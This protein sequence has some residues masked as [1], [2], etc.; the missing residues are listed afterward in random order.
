MRRIAMISEKGGTGKTTTAINVAVGLAKAGSR[1]LVCDLDPQSNAS[2][3]FLEG[4]GAESPTIGAV[5]LDQADAHDAIR[6]TSTLGLD[7]LP[8]DVSLADAN[9][10]LASEVGRERRLRVALE[11]VRDRYDV[12]VL[13][14]SPQRS[15]LT[16]NALVFAEE[17]YV[18][19]D[20]GLFAVAGLGQLQATV[21][22]VRRYLDNRALRIAAL[23]L[24]RCRND[25][26]GRDVESQL[27]QMFGELVRRT[28]V[29]TNAKIE[30][31][32]SRYQS[33][34]DYAPRS[35][36]AKAYAE[37]VLEIIAD[38]RTTNGARGTPDGPAATHHAA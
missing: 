28:T 30:E 36:G 2:L 9:L 8:A 37:L 31:A 13:D 27:R 3:V 5:L 29:P 15:L 11:E 4:R 16:V 32:H 24:T 6:P 1:V 12:V 21:D 23:I 38:G 18:P 33:V 7:I 19:I 22:E 17:V 34:L 10:A 20:P 14:T 26:V 25:N 35:A